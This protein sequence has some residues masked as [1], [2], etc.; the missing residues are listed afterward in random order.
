KLFAV[1][2][3]MSRSVLEGG[4]G[5]PAAAGST[6]RPAPDGLVVCVVSAASCAWVAGSGNVVVKPGSGSDALDV[7]KSGVTAFVPPVTPRTARS[8]LGGEVGTP[9]ADSTSPPRASPG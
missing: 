8:A 6:A 9:K 3:K 7:P 1:A 5:V 2:N 4:A